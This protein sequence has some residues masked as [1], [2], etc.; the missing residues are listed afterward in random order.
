[1][2]RGGSPATAF[3]V[4][5]LV[6][7][8][9][10]SVLSDERTFAA[11]PIALLAAFAFASERVAPVRRHPVLAAIA[12]ALFIGATVA[13]TGGA[14]SPMLP[15]LL[16]PGLA[17]GLS[18]TWRQVV[19]TTVAAA[20]GLLGGRAIQELRDETPRF[21]AGDD[22]AVTAGQWV[23]LGLAFGLIAGWAQRLVVQESPDIADRYGE[24][25]RLLEQ[26]RGVTRRLP[27]GLDVSSSADALL[28]R[29][30]EVA[31]Y[32]RAAVLVRP[33]NGALVP[34]AVR[35]TQR[36]PWRAPLS[37]PGPLQR[38]WDS[39]EPL[40]DRRKPDTHG[41]RQGS[42]LA[43]L[44]LA[45]G[46]EPFGLLILEAYDEAAFD[47]VAL[48]LLRQ[49]AVE[50]ALRLETALLFDEVRSTVTVE[51]RD[52][53]ARD[54]HDGVAQELA[55][56]GYQLDDLRIRASKV[57][58][59][60]A[61]SMSE[62]RKGLTSLI[63]DIRLSITDLKT[64]ISNDRGLGAAI[65]GYLRAVGSGQQ[66]V[67]HVSLK[68]STFRLAGDQEVLLFQ[69]A[70]VV[71]QDVRRSGQARNLWVTLDVD[72]PSARLVVEHDGGDGAV[73]QLH[74]NDYAEHLTRL[75]GELRVRLRQDGGIRVEAVL[76]GGH[77]GDQR[78]AGR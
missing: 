58:A 20:A 67:V 52:R 69:I 47:R 61:E 53:L 6:L 37:E 22:F 9:V 3:R 35:G 55:F 1:M 62:V 23:L 12:E 45:T 21:F 25:R 29:C 11:L 56:V 73:D 38:A 72:P 13:V 15:Y 10:L 66:V 5:L 7:C 57:D 64:S 39:R 51:E 65:T 14:Q 27:G 42:S 2:R 75:G 32:N 71:A 34:A 28:E 48:E 19:V 77:G 43:V 78:P 46:D 18:G 16:A 41:R 60:L 49:E 54:M 59:G 33:G 30:A 40:V 74:L 24:A 36:V 70:Q 31:P 4:T 50:G 44:P 63:S 17:M 76:E 8:S 26:L 68:E